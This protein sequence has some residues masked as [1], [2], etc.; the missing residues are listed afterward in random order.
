MAFV[1]REDRLRLVVGLAA[2]I[3]TA[4]VVVALWFL[5]S[6]GGADPR[7]QSALMAGDTASARA[8]GE[9]TARTTTG[10][11]I[12]AFQ[13]RVV[14]RLRADDP[15]VRPITGPLDVRAR[16]LRWLEAGGARFAE[17]ASA[18]GR[19]DLAAAGRGDVIIDDVVL[20][21]PR[22]ALREG[23]SGWNYEVVLAELLGG[24][25]GGA[26][27]GGARRVI[28]RNIRI[29]DGHVDV[30]RPAE[31]FT[32]EALEAR[33]PAIWF[34]DPAFP[35]PTVRIATATAVLD[36]ADQEPLPVAAE[37]AEIRLPD[38]PVEFDVAR[39]AVDGMQ[40][41]DVTGAWNPEWAFPGLNARGRAIGVEFATLA[42][43]APDRLPEEGTATFGWQIVPLEGDRIE[44]ALSDLT[45]TTGA[46]SLAGALTV[47]LGGTGP[48]ELR[49]ADLRV[50]PVQL[51]LI[52]RFAGPL[53]YDGELTGTV[54]G[55]EGDI[56]FDLLADL[57]PDD[58]PADRFTTAVQGRIAMTGDGFTLRGLE[59]DLQGVPLA[60]LRAFIP[61]LPFGGYVSGTVALSGMPD[62]TPLALDVSLALGTGTVTAQGTVDLTGAVPAYDLEGRILALE[63]PAVLRPRAPP[64][65]LTANFAVGGTGF[66]PAMAEAS[67]Q[68]AGR[69]TGWETD[70]SDTLSLAATVSGGVLFVETLNASV[71]TASLTADGRWRFVSPQE[72]AIQ[73]ALEVTDLEP[74]DPY[75][76]GGGNGDA[77]GRL[78]AIGSLAG[79]LSRPRLDGTIEGED[80]AMAGW[81]ASGLDLSYELVVGDSLPQVV[82]AGTAAGIVTPSA[83]EFESAMVDGRLV[84]PDFHL[85]LRADRAN[86]GGVQV[87]ADGRLP[88]SGDRELILQQ[89]EADV[90]GGRWTLVRPATIDVESGGTVMVGG[91]EMVESASGGRVLI[92]GTVWPIAVADARIEAAELPVGDVQSLLGITP[93]V[94][95]DLAAMAE[96][97]TTD[98]VPFIDATF[99][100][101]SGAIRG[102]PV[103]RFEGSVRFADNTID[104]RAMALLDTA[105]T[106]DL[107]LRLPAEL[108]LD[109]LSFRLLDE[110]AVSGT[111]DARDLALA[112]LAGPTTALR[113]VQGRINGQVT[114]TGTVGAP[115]LAGQLLMVGGAATVVPLDQ[116]FT[117][118]GADLV[119]SGR[120][121]TVRQLSATSDGSVLVRG[122]IT[123][124]QLTDPVAALAVQVSRFRPFGV[125]GRENAAFSGTITLQGSLR[126]PLMTGRVAVNDGY[127]PIPDFGGPPDDFSDLPGLESQE[128]SWLDALRIDNMVV[129]VAN[130]VWFT[131]IGATAQLGGEVA[132]SKIGEAFRLQGTLEGERGTYTLE[133]GPIIRRFQI[134]SAQVRFLGTPEINPAIDVTARRIVLDPAGRQVEIDVRITGT[135]RTP[136]LSLASADLATVPESELLSFL[137]FGR[138]SADLGTGG[139]PGQAL[140]E[141]TFVGGFAELA[142]LEL[143]RTLIRDLGL[144]FDVFQIRFGGPGGIGG[145][146]APTLVFG[147]ELGSAFFLTVESALGALAESGAGIENSWAIRLEWAFDEDSRARIGYEPVSINRFLRGYSLGLDRVIQNQ[148]VLEVRRRW[149]Y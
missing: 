112:P 55:S 86:G 54:R 47:R 24:G 125:E 145:F 78:A 37:D 60:S 124:E 20:S 28:V 87:V 13:R 46:S 56:T 48:L 130:D 75:I 80:L 51:S 63:L 108:R 109:S 57:A 23:R 114:L 131:G 2:G 94:T 116:R 135:I 123:F 25:N 15:P 21:S 148:F 22:V 26:D 12:G 4:L 142:G 105:G 107:A 73:Y 32:I 136:R 147:W 128:E 64:V 99:S 126:S 35:E 121:L 50:D 5:K 89:L 146:G 95:G 65:A 115:D 68:V 71:A 127:I 31:S 19:V 52:E 6:G 141:E 90:E 117:Q 3:I 93:Q 100:L 36:L 39:L 41:A 42:R 43:Y 74:W 82:V 1:P 84:A 113:D 30:I 14:E 16:S 62:R 104:V 140:L 81:Q 77:A 132:V 59:A 17:A 9:R 96:I 149:M 72:G 61:G 29:A 66:D 98:G 134:A 118:I 85:S 76:P 88:P 40:L 38:G 102:V 49:A 143:E 27:N 111:L 129:A 83:G 34:A 45:A 67:V 110:G 101:D 144:S 69:F 7:V 119:L 138:P 122:E 44:I 53:P 139:L 92:D 8:A 18:T 10:P 91:L 133:A 97:G 70:A 103:S 58:S 137:F 11:L 79:E 106:L 33:L 120:T